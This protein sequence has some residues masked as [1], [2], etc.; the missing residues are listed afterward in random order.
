WRA[1]GSAKVGGMS[2]ANA[3]RPVIFRRN[4]V[5]ICVGKQEPP[6]LQ[7]DDGGLGLAYARTAGRREYRFEDAISSQQPGAGERDYREDCA[8]GSHAAFQRITTAALA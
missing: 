6:I 1:P 4:G 3:G 5:E 2:A 8:S 7:G